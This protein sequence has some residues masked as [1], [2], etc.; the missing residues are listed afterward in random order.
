M[1]RVKQLSYR[2]VKM[3]AIVPVYNEQGNIG[4]FLAVLNQA[5]NKISKNYEI[6]IIDDGSNDKTLD[7]IVP[8]IQEYPLRLFKF[9]RQF[10]KEAAISAGLQYCRGEVAIIIDADFQHPVELIY[11]FMSTWAQGYDM[12]YGVLE[13]RKHQYWF[14]RLFSRS[15]Y[16][17]INKL[18]KI[19]I[20]YN[21]GD[22]RLLDRNII[23]AINQC[24][25]R[26]RFMKG[27]YAWVGY[28]SIGIHYQ[29]QSR[30]SG[31]SAWSLNKLF[32]LA[33][34]GITSFS[35]IPLR[36]WGFIGAF[37]SCLSFIYMLYVILNTLI[38]GADVPGY[39]TLL[40]AILFLGGIQLISIGI[41]GEYIG[42]IFNEVKNRPPYIIE[43]KIEHETNHML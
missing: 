18:V 29:A 32:G 35:S 2:S 37:I 16:W 14:N 40:T 7:I 28:R 5:L 12:V 10:G 3:T 34:T 4:D 11:S 13:N 22:F 25:E 1:N 42:R 41:L 8:L 6:V 24:R 20:P 36:I 31:K 27:L 23:D 30:R 26:H 21:A 17:L 43:K 15:F 33:I 19:N 9:S 38:F 39:A